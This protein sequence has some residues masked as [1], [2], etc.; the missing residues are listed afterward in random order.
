ML[1]MV[2]VVTRLEYCANVR[3]STGHPYRHCFF[4]SSAELR[5]GPWCL[6]IS[7]HKAG[8]GDMWRAQQF[9]L[10]LPAVSHPN[11]ILEPL[12]LEPMET[13][14]YGQCSSQLRKPAHALQRNQPAP[15]LNPY[16]EKHL[17][18]E[19]ARQ[20]SNEHGCNELD[21]RPGLKHFNILLR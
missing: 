4:R 9:V 16:I 15:G 21:P 20:R 12:T 14:V 7:T 19:G 5:A 8:H 10:R 18:P 6:K 11:L 17:T 1:H 2:K 13:R 3:C